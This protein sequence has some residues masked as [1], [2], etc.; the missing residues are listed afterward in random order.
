MDS[1]L[2][3]PDGTVDSTVRGGAVSKSK[4]QRLI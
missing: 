2:P 1:F 3:R 4:K